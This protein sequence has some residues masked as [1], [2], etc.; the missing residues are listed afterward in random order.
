MNEAFIEG[1][2]QIGSLTLRPWTSGSK[3]YASKMGLTIFEGKIEGLL[4]SEIEWQVHAFA[5]MQ[6]APLQEVILSVRNGSFK[7]KVDA[8]M[9]SVSLPLLPQLCDEITRIGEMVK[10]QMI[11]VAPRP[12]SSDKDAPPN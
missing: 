7:E 6:S 12:N 3:M 11:A 9:F 10:A 5:W 1:D 4:E 2:R 8:F